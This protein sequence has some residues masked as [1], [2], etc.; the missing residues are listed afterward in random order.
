MYCK[1]SLDRFSDAMQEPFDAAATLQQV[2]SKVD[3]IKVPGLQR[4][5]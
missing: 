3:V 2:L 4:S 5:T 1:R